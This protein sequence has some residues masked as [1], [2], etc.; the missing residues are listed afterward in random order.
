MT[1]KRGNN[2]KTINEVEKGFCVTQHKGV[3]IVFAN[4]WAISIQWGPGNYITD[5]TMDWM[6]PR[7]NDFTGSVDAE[8]AIFQP[9]GNWYRPEGEDW[10][11]DVR[12]HCKP[13]EVLRYMN[14]IA[15]KPS[16]AKAESK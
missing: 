15:S 9:N 3:R 8:I 11:D 10:D 5:R 4:K 1:H 16:T 14:L 7:N 13:D 6:A 12:G 2:M